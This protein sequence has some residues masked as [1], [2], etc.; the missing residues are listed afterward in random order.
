MVLSSEHRPEFKTEFIYSVIRAHFLNHSDPLPPFI[1][2]DYNM[3]NSESDCGIE[4]KYRV[5]LVVQR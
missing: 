1:K 2:G 3:P 5:S 4:E